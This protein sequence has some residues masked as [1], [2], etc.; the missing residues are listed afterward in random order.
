MRDEQDALHGGANTTAT[1]LFE[2]A[3]VANLGSPD[4]AGE[5]L[6]TMAYDF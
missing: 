1:R 5:D 2:D 6:V 3:D 4:M